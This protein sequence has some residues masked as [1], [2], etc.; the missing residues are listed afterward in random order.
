MK[1]RALPGPATGASALGTLFI[2]PKIKKLFFTRW[3]K[4]NFLYFFINRVKGTSPLARFGAE[5]Q[6]F[7]FVM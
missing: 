2:K 3:A 6:G 7:Q 5:L 4:N 1:T